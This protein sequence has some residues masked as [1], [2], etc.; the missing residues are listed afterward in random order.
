M[1]SA[2]ENEKPHLQEHQ[3]VLRLP[4]VFTEEIESRLSTEVT[5][6]A[7]RRGNTDRE[8]D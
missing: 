1:T 3:A 2:F 4:V 6:V 8:D 5:H 7:I